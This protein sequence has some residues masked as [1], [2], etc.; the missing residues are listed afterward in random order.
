VAVEVF[1]AAETKAR[2]TG[3]ATPALCLVTKIDMRRTVH[4]VGA[5]VGFYRLRGRSRGVP[6]LL[7][8]SW[9]LEGLR[10]IVFVSLW[11][12]ETAISDFGTAVPQH[13][14]HVM[15]TFRRGADIWSGLFEIVGPSRSSGGWKSVEQETER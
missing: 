8:A 4:M 11:E 3:P 2:P 12:S 10:T 14:R 15:R 6:G 13:P 5:V 1:E 9:S 7:H